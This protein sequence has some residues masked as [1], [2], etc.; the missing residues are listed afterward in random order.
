MPHFLVSV[1]YPNVLHIRLKPRWFQQFCAMNN[2]ELASIA[3]QVRRDIVRMVHAVQS[4]HPG[5]SL[6]VLTWMVKLYFD[7][8][9][10]NPSS[11]RHGR[12]RRGLVFSFQWP[13]QSSMVQ[14]LGEAIEL[15]EL[16][17]SE[18]E[19]PFAKQVTL[20][21]RKVFRAFELLQGRSAK[22]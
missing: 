13:H 22:A 20:Q 17:H 4:G 9:K 7:T 18:T 8:M 1:D 19:Q 11:F 14:R 21:L 6:G 12:D 2:S 15:S 10:I 3:I 5:G 16:R